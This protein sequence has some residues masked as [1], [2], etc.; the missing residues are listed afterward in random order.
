MFKVKPQL[1]ELFYKHLIIVFHK[2]ICRENVYQAFF[3]HYN[4]GVHLETFRHLK[5]KGF[6]AYWVPIFLHFL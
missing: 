1:L 4:V 6:N 5:D 2:N 3:K